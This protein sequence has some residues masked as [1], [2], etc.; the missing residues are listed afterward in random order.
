MNR[1]LLLFATISFHEYYSYLQLFKF[2]KYYSYSRI[3][4][5]YS[6]ISYLNIKYE[7]ISLWFCL[8]G[9]FFKWKIYR[10]REKEIMRKKIEKKKKKCQVFMNN[11]WI[12]PI[13]WILFLFL[14]AS[15]KIHEVFLFLFVHKLAPQIYSYSYLRGK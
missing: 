7:N 13:W 11:L 8:A 1:F 9:K 2:D 10:S 14:S 3:F 5:K 12:L 6:L 15:F 4:S